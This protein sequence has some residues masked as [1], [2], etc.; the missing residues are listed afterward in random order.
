MTIRRSGSGAHTAAASPPSS[1][2]SSV[3][4]TPGTSTVATPASS[5]S[6]P[7]TAIVAARKTTPVVTAAVTTVTPQGVATQAALKPPPVT[8]IKVPAAL[9]TALQKAVTPAGTPSGNLT[10]DLNVISEAITKQKVGDLKHT[11]MVLIKLR[12]VL[13][14]DYW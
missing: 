4:I 3:P 13:V 12:F 1:Y 7:V 5:A 14:T 9:Q 10:H 6:T 11:T 2:Q 8:P